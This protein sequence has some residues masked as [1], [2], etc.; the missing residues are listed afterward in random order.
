MNFG[1]A[2]SIILGFTLSRQK[3]CTA[4]CS[5][6]SIRSVICPYVYVYIFLQFTVFTKVLDSAG[7]ER[8]SNC[9][10]TLV[11]LNAGLLPVLA[12]ATPF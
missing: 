9:G 4:A 1:V 3:C 12:H 11:G 6:N 8:P 7:K 5:T 2:Y 10:L